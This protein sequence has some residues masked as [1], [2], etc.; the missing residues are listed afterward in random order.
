VAD[1]SIA[2][3]KLPKGTNKVLRAKIDAW[4]ASHR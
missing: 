4:L 3:A 1:S 2:L